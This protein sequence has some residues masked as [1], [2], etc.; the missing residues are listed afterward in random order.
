MPFNLEA[1]AERL[2][3][4]GHIPQDFAELAPGMVVVS[5]IRPPQVMSSLHISEAATQI[6]GQFA[7]THKVEAV[8]EDVRAH[9][10]FPL[11]VGDIVKCY[12]AHLDPLDP[13]GNLL[14]IPRQHVKGVV[15]RATDRFASVP[16]DDAPKAA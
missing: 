5:P 16:E 10:E 9:A 11:A 6:P 8:A 14:S 2:Y 3:R 13:K 4:R 15:C 7:L 1:Y 12:E